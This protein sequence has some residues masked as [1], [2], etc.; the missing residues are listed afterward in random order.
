MPIE[1]SW[2]LY[3][4]A[5]KSRLLFIPNP[6]GFGNKNILRNV[7]A[8]V[9]VRAKFSSQGYISGTK[10]VTSW[11][12]AFRACRPMDD[13]AWSLIRSVIFLCAP[14]ARVLIPAEAKMTLTALLTLGRI[15]KKEINHERPSTRG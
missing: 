7:I 15:S 8:R 14:M 6:Q 9:S 11:R 4:I 5:G 13:F 3:R 12:S 10:T 1:A 2:C